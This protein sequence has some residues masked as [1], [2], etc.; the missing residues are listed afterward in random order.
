MPAEQPPPLTL[1]LLGLL[2]VPP[3]QMR[4][5]PQLDCRAQE[6]ERQRSPAHLTW[7]AAI[8]LMPQGPTENDIWMSRTEVLG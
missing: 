4:L 3:L 2:P 7:N 5:C 6:A 8:K 1:T